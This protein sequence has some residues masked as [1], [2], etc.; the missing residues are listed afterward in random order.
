MPS[1]RIVFSKN[2]FAKMG[3]DKHYRK[4]A[5]PEVVILGLGEMEE[6]CFYHKII[7]RQFSV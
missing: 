3:N 2:I 6:K 5:K 1:C 7:L 4:C